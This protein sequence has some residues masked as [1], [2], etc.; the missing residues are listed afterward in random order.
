MFPQIYSRPENT[1]VFKKQCYYEKL[2]QH[3]LFLV[4]NNLK[5]TETA[6]KWCIAV[7]V[8][9]FILYVGFCKIMPNHIIMFFLCSL[10][11]SPRLYSM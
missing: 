5:L 11:R 1:T 10:S 8:S 9:R 3:K 4:L 2:Q 7:L 6:S